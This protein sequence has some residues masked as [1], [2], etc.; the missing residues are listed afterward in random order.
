MV[1]GRLNAGDFETL[2]GLPDGVLTID[3]ARE[4]PEALKPR[5]IP[6]GASNDQPVRK[7]ENNKSENRAA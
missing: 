4:V 3:L 7:I 6:I 5:R 2:V 1:A